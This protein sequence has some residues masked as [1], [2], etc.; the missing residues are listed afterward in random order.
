MYANFDIFLSHSYEDAEVIAGVKALI[1]KDDL[2]VYVDWIVDSQA[3]RSQVTAGTAG[4]LR[5][6]MN[7]CRFLLYASSSTSP[8]SRWMPWE[9]GYFDGLNHGNVGVLP[10]VQSAGNAFN[11]QEYLSLYPSYELLYFPKHG[12]R[13]GRRVSPGK[14]KRLGKILSDIRSRVQ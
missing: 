1:E 9:L 3:D 10:I 12:E 13:F 14:K 5:Q 2:T 11:G 7:H 4:M 6:R 8:S